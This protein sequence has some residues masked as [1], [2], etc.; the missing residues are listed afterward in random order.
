MNINANN[1]IFNHTVM[2]VLHCA[3][4]VIWN[5]QN[6]NGIIEKRNTKQIGQHWGQH[7]VC[8]AIYVIK[9]WFTFGAYNTS[10]SASFTS[11][12]AFPRFALHILNLEGSDSATLGTKYELQKSPRHGIQ[13]QTQHSKTMSKTSVFEWEHA[14]QRSRFFLDFVTSATNAWPGSQRIWETSDAFCSVAI[15]RKKKFSKPVLSQRVTVEPFTAFLLAWDLISKY[16][17]LDRD[18]LSNSYIVL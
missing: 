12:Q 10:H 5:E 9:W 8:T 11:L 13:N 1:S 18:L 17:D 7:I 16:K 6:N 14:K 3:L 4:F 2:A 15:A